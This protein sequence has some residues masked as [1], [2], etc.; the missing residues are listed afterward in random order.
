MIERHVVKRS[1][2]GQHL[3]QQG[4]G[5]QRQIILGLFPLFAGVSILAACVFV[6]QALKG[7]ADFRQLY[8]GAY[9]V[10]TGL[11]HQLYDLDRQREIENRVVSPSAQ[12]LPVNHP[13]YE[14][15][16]FMP[17]SLLAY[18][19]AY[20]TWAAI[21]VLVLAFCGTRLAH[22]LDRWAAFALL[23]GFAPVWATLMHGQDSVWLLFWLLLSSEAKSERTAGLLLGM[24]A[25]RFHL[26]IPLLVIFALWKAWRVIFGALLAAA[27]L[28]I[29]SVWLV[30]I[31]GSLLYLKAAAA[32]TEVR[33]GLPVNP[34]GICQAILGRQHVRAA[35]VLAF[36]FAVAAIWYAS[37]RKPSLALALVTLS[38]ASYYLMPHD[39][40]FLLIPLSVLL[41]RS[42]ASVFQFGISVLGLFPPI[43]FFVCIAHRATS[44]SLATEPC[45]DLSS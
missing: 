36:R 14:Y 10:R 2:L 29:V 34:F 21:N 37:S 4:S 41:R 22:I 6:P 40:V 5:W 7:N 17:L 33:N 9:M 3:I 28:G 44:V 18:R 13:A 23:A 45:T 12:V 38:L 25:F 19:W 32:S 8:A 39:L 1:E 11:R 31:R 42:W 43:A 16:F 35:L 20:G 27:R 26:L 15:L 24:T 30:G